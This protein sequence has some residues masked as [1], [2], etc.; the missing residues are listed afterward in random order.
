M[1]N[2]WEVF[3]MNGISYPKCVDFD[4][5]LMKNTSNFCDYLITGARQNKAY[6]IIGI[7]PVLTCSSYHLVTTIISLKSLIIYYLTEELYVYD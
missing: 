2:L 5:N 4:E 6:N 1:Q 7:H 3:E